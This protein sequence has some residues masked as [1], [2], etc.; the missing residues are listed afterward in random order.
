MPRFYFDYH[1]HTPEHTSI[2]DIG[3][4][5]P[6]VSAAKAEAACAAV[7]WMK[8]HLSESETELRLSVRDGAPA[9]VFVVTASLK[10][11]DGNG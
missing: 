11:S 3:T 10:V 6:D 7:E 8:D 4:E 1:H 2:D 9:P 5:L